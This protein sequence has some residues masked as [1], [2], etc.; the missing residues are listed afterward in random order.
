MKS[1]WADPLPWPNRRDR[2]AVGICPDMVG[3]I[4]EILTMDQVAR[5]YG[6]EP[7]RAGFMKCPFH[8]ERT[9]SLKIYPGHKGWHCFGCGKGGSVIDFVMELYGIGFAQAVVRLNADFG[10]GLTAER[11]SPSARTKVLEE[12]RR[13]A[14]KARRMREEY[15][16]LAREH[17]FLREYI[18]RF[19]PTRE[20]WESGDVDPVYIW[21]LKRL[22]EAEFRCE[23]LSWRLMKDRA[24]N[25]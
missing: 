10:L 22:P 25:G 7:T 20:E 19:E 17:L 13:A 1:V 21:A 8:H 18:R 2:V 5:R 16:V 14:E 24:V 11:P 3:A 12:R 4:K 9:A 6:F 15:W 23:E